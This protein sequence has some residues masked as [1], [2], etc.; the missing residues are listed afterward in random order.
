MDL[1]QAKIDVMSQNFR[2]KR[3]KIELLDFTLKKIDSIEGNV[4]SGSITA[5]ANSDIRRTGNI[6]LAIPIN[7]DASTFFDLL[8]GFTISIG[9]KIWL[10]KYVK[11]YVGI[12]SSDNGIEWYSLGVFLIDEPVRSVS[13]NQHIISFQCID[14]MAKLTG[15]RQGQ[16]TGTTTLIEKG[17]YEIIDG[18]ETYIKTEISQALASIITELGG[19]TKYAI[20][21]IPALK[22]YLPYDIKV[23][24]GATVYNILKEM[25]DI[26]A[27][28]QM[29]FDTDGVLRIEPIP[30]GLR[31]IVYDIET[32]KY[33]TD[34]LSVSFSNV[35]N[36]VVVY[37]RVNTLSYYTENTE[38]E[39]TNVV[40]DDTGAYITL[41]LKYPSEINTQSLTISGS[42]FGFK[43]LNEYNNKRIN[44]VE[45]WSN[46]E[47]F[48][49]T[50]DNI[51]ISLVDFENIE[52]L[53]NVNKLAPNEVYFLRIFEA[54]LTE[55]NVVD[56]EQSVKFEFMGKQA[57]AGTLVNDNRYS[58][59]YINAQLPNPNYY[60][61]LAYGVG[62]D[63]QLTLNNIGTLNELENGTII[64]FMANATNLSNPTITVLNNYGNTILTNIPLLQNVG[65]F[66]DRPSVLPN[67]LGNDFTIHKI[68]YEYDADIPIQN[69]V[70]LGRHTEALTKVLSGGEYDNIYADQ[71]A[72]ERCKYELFISS[73]LNNSIQIGIVPNYNLDVNKKI[74]Y[75]ER[76]SQL[77]YELPNGNLLV[78]T[79]T[80]NSYNRFITTDLYVY[81]LAV[82]KQYYI[83]KRITYPL[84]LDASP[85]VVEAIQIY[86]S[87]NLMGDDYE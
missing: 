3:I 32:D 34:T 50:H 72:F 73:N 44:R 56:I 16:L 77:L 71:L 35:K 23:G 75:D 5:D 47:K 27:T 36:Q 39:Q 13:A 43:S 84:G 54:T 64:T 15:K 38:E 49:Y 17:Y 1:T 2:S 68:K 80:K 31:D 61:G 19:F 8:S 74:P 46:G 41:I 26:L 82:E 18:K 29:Y 59:Y 6:E 24:V 20:Y 11:I 79:G 78:Q 67:K 4:I 87:G 65:T 14:L 33:I 48:L 45:I 22:K 7:R 58:P 53:L 40:Y 76:Y 55:D 66:G 60:A 42:T 51:I 86:D 81:T 12:D 63:Y 69:F 28:W 10:D 85:Q 70:Y 30:S 37:G 57:I 21:P 62:Q 83:T 52:S 25:L 9:G